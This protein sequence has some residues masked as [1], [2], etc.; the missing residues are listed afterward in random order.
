M[1]FWHTHT[2][3]CFSPSRLLLPSALIHTCEHKLRGRPDKL[4]SCQAAGPISLLW[5]N[6][7]TIRGVTK[8]LHL[9]LLPPLPVAS[10]WGSR[11]WV[12]ENC[13]FA[14][15]PALPA[16]G[17]AIPKPPA[18]FWAQRSLFRAFPLRFPPP[19]VFQEKINPSWL[20]P[21]SKTHS[22]DVKGQ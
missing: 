7:S 12:N 19:P 15:S 13:G 17:Y 18:W 14:L 16:L 1:P 10:C 5:G 20:W 3:L 11:C 4:I 9:S 8:G 22:S 6:Y 21:D 2:S